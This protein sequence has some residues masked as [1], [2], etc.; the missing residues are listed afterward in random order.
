M[1]ITALSIKENLK[2]NVEDNIMIQLVSEIANLND[3]DTNSEKSRLLI[4]KLVDICG[5]KEKTT[6][7]IQ[8]VNKYKIA[9]NVG[10]IE[11]I[12]NN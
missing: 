12:K 2:L 8:N 1:E 10:K 6:I 4:I 3:D 5:T 7:F 11:D 9:E